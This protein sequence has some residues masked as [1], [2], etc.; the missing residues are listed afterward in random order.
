MRK[1]FSVLILAIVLPLVS[2]LV[3]A[4]TTFSSQGDDYKLRVAQ[5]LSRAIQF[6][7]IF[8]QNTAEVDANEFKAFHE[9]LEKTFPR[10]HSELTREVINGY[11]LLYTWK[12]SDPNAKPLIYMAHMDVVPI[13]PGT[14]EKWTYPPFEGRIADGFIW[15]RGTMDDKGSL[16][17]IMESVEALLAEGYKPIRTIYL[18]F[19]QD[20]EVG[21]EQ[22]AKRIAAQLAARGV[23]AEYVL[24]E[25]GLIINSIMPG[26]STPVAIIG[27]AEKG[28]L[29][30]ELSVQDEGG[31]SSMPPRH[32]AIGILAGAIV[33]LEKKQFPAR[34]EGPSLQLLKA[35]SAEMPAGRRFA[36][37]NSWLFRPIIK[38]SLAANKVTNASIRTTFATTI[39]HAGSKDNVLPQEARAVV[40]FRL[41]PGDSIDY[42]MGRVRKAI[43]DPRVKITILGQPG[44]ASS[45]SDV[46]SQAYKTLERT[47]K[48]L[49]PEVIVAP[50]LVLGGTDA[51]HYGAVSSNI[52][53][54]FP[55][56]AG[57]SDVARAHGTDERIAVDNYMELIRFYTKL[58]K[59][60]N[61]D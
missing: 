58:I 38:K 26:V 4:P 16:M 2:V 10:I 32:S 31:H 49:F 35:I 15:G 52:L 57:Q 36:I 8:Q 7:T 34:L 6:K 29:S 23:K 3:S 13:A 59:N 55:V 46:N 1:S 44:E 50:Y 30:I 25:S 39:I 45:V 33:R 21:G 27:V 17:A 51:K 18:C 24:D 5:N 53:R 12:G 54:F 48:E 61:A 22:G 60:S 14:L 56:R 37:R 28:Y 20:E 42:V 11:G 41:L 40:N 43:N 9:F 19:G 47:I